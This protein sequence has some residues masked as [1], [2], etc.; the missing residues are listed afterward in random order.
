[1]QLGPLC[2]AA[3]AQRRRHSLERLCGTIGWSPAPDWKEKGMIELTEQEQQALDTS[4]EPPRLIDPRTNAAYVL[5]RAE[6][7]ERLR[8]L[9]DDDLDMKQVAL[10][11]DRAMRDDDANDPTLAF[12]QQKYGRKP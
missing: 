5:V 4:S 11:V 6:V 8:G 1:L 3:R 9:L 2:T 10:L 7:Y 12:Y